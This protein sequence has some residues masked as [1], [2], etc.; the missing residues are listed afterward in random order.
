MEI[1]INISD[2][3]GTAMGISCGMGA[4]DRVG[5]V[6]IRETSLLSDKTGETIKAPLLLI[7]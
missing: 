6:V 7:W 2:N 5:V 4:A 1:N 3:W